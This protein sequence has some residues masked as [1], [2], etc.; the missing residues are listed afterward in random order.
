MLQ[1]NILGVSH[2]KHEQEYHLVR[3]K[4]Q[5]AINFVHFISPAVVSLGGTDHVA[6]PDSCIIYMP[7]CRQEYRS[8]KGTLL[9]NYIT[10]E[11]SDPDF[12][13][14]FGLPENMLFTI[15]DGSR[16][17]NIMEWL[18]WAVADKTEPHG[19]DIVER[20]LGLFDTLSALYIDKNPGLRRII[21]T[22]MRFIALRDE[23][24]GCPVGWDIDKM[25]KQV[26]LSRSRFTVLYKDFFCVP[27]KED[28]IN[29]KLKCAKDLLENTDVSV[30]NVAKK[31]GYDSVE[32]FI[33]LFSQRMG[34]T[35]LKYRKKF[36]AN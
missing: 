36:Q 17:T 31:C 7:G 14:R 27:P 3:E 5:P 18:A 26:W 12:V 24:R 33:R 32:H 15:S 16:V 20:V 22:K 11:V 2:R 1:V 29:I 23:M 34:I 25:A 21:E 4:G 10:F 9:N 13:G 6:G 28:L 8:H 19:D 35:P 30:K